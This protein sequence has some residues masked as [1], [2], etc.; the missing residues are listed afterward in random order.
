[1]VEDGHMQDLYFEILR[2]WSDANNRSCGFLRLFCCVIDTEPYAHNKIV[3]I[4]NS[5]SFSL[6]NLHYSLKLLLRNGK[7]IH[8]SVVHKH[9]MMSTIPISNRVQSGSSRFAYN[10]GTPSLCVSHRRCVRWSR[11]WPMISSLTDASR[12]LIFVTK[13]A[14]IVA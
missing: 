2:R 7:W 3:L 1:M 14:L 5:D 10:S 6:H 13:W 8:N 12:I 11:Y 9:H 4:H